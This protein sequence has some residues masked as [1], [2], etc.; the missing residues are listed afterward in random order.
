MNAACTPNGAAMRFVPGSRIILQSSVLPPTFARRA[1]PMFAAGFL[2]AAPHSAAP[3]LSSSL[4]FDFI[5][6][7]TARAN[8]GGA[9]IS[10][11]RRQTKKTPP[12]GATARRGVVS[13]RRKEGHLQPGQLGGCFHQRGWLSV[14]FA[15]LEPGNCFDYPHVR[16]CVSR[17]GRAGRSH[18]NGTF[19]AAAPATS[20]QHG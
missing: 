10:R 16:P 15:T 4:H 9:L 19:C 2:Q 5:A 8:H 6:R 17:V 11:R 1:P 14:R 13:P 3:P 20:N 7:L 18:S 12:R